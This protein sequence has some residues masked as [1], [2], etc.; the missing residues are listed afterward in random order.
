MVNY[1]CGFQSHLELRFSYYKCLYS[2]WTAQNN[3]NTLNLKYS[4]NRKITN[5][6]ANEVTSNFMAD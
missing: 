6:T 5:H 1:G 4:W 3:N 2:S